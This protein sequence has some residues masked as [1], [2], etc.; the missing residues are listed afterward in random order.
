MRKLRGPQSAEEIAS[1]VAKIR[2]LRLARYLAMPFDELGMENRRRRVFEEQDYK[3]NRC[4]ID[5]WFDQII[6]LELEHKDGNN[7]NNKRENLEGL[8]PNCHSLT[9]TWRG[10]NKKTMGP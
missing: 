7:K 5:K 2:A 1:R 3:C 10:R 8:C 9:P 6:S 4:G